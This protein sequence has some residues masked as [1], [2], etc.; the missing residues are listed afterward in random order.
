LTLAVLFIVGLI[1]AAFLALR[2]FLAATVWAT[3]LVIA[4]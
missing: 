2:P 1:V 4:T 3:M